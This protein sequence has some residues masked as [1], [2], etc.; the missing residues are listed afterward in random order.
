MWRPHVWV[1]NKIVVVP[2]TAATPIIGPKIDHPKPET[3]VMPKTIATNTNIVPKYIELLLR[4]GKMLVLN[5]NLGIDGEHSG[6][7]LRYIFILNSIIE[8]LIV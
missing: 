4:I 2:K 8:K 3:S 1:T 7:I 5:D 6:Y